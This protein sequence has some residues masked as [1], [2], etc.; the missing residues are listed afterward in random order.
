MSSENKDNQK[1]ERKPLVNA[2][3][4]VMVPVP[5]SEAEEF[6][7]QLGRILVKLYTKCCVEGTKA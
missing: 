3:V 2:M 5:E 4:V 1:R 7:R 6:R